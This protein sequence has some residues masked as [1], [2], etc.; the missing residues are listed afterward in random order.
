[1][2]PI[3]LPAA[4]GASQVTGTAL[5]WAAGILRG[6]GAAFPAARRAAGPAGDRKLPGRAASES[7]SAGDRPLAADRPAEAAAQRDA[8]G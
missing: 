7:A 1:L 4:R 2:T 3:L 8:A 6:L 5:T